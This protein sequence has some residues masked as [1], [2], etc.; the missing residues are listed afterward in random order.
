MKAFHIL[1]YVLLLLTIISCS[2]I[3]KPGVISNESVWFENALEVSSH[4]LEKAAEIYYD[5]IFPRSIRADGTVEIVNQF[6]WTSGFFPGSLWY[7]YELTNNKTLKQYAIESTESINKV[8]LLT[9]THDLGFMLF[10]S[11]GNGLRLTE[12]NKYED[13]LITGAKSLATRYNDKIKSIRS[14]D[15]NE[16]PDNWQ[17]PV[18][19]DNMMNLEM[20]QWAYNDTKDSTFNYIT[21][22]HANTTLKN[23]YRD[24]Y[25]SFH[26]VSYDTITAHVERKQTHQGLSDSSSWA[27]GQAWGLYGFTMMYKY[28][29]NDVFL[30]QA[31]NIA[32]FI[33]NHPNLPENKIPYW[34]FDVD[35][36][37]KAP[38]DASAA[39]IMASAFIDLSELSGNS[40]YFSIAEQ[41]LKELSSKEYLA[42]KDTNQFFILKHST[43]GYPQNH[44]IDTAINYAD[45]YYLEAMSK[46]KKALK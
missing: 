14:W 16:E 36:F 8:H 39:A 24:D 37:E 30:N 35:N 3:D 6:D 15:F 13:V 4:Q 5:G 12:N 44:E 25:S 18:I 23:H 31:T 41:I 1:K 40:E 29:K 17:F 22:N 11:Y 7:A 26:V 2:K 28:T 34:D 10:C 21:V 20:L 27:R 19:V 9:N 38:R 33:L 46:Y 32:S 45:Y 42:E 43:G